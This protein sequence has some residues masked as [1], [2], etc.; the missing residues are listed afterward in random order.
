MV[1]GVVRCVTPGRPR[2]RGVVGCRARP[3]LPGGACSRASLAVRFVA[4]SSPFGRHGG[5]SE[6]V[7]SG[8]AS[9]ALAQG[10]FSGAV[11]QWSCGDS[12]RRPA[13]LNGG[14]ATTLSA[15]PAPLRSPP[16]APAQVVP[17]PALVW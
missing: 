17:S 4:A 6:V 14:R 8:L 13:G 7:W 16:A 5:A 9:S 2:W 11:L 10:T 3:L 1:C 12:A 15:S